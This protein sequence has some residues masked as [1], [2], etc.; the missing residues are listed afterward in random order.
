MSSSCDYH[1]WRTVGDVSV[2]I[3]SV[4]LHHKPTTDTRARRAEEE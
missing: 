4:L 1:M 2:T 3:S